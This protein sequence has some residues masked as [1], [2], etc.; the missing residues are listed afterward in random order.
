M[1][2]PPPVPPVGEVDGAQ[3]DPL[4]GQRALQAGA[5]MGNGV[6][7]AAP[8]P[9]LAMA[10]SG[11]LPIT[12]LDTGLDLPIGQPQPQLAEAEAVSKLQQP[13]LPAPGLLPQQAG[14]PRAAPKEQPTA[15]A[16]PVMLIEQPTLPLDTLQPLPPASPAPR[17][18]SE[19]PPPLPLPGYL[20]IPAPGGGTLPAPAAAASHLPGLVPSPGLPAALAPP[21]ASGVLPPPRPGLQRV[22]SQTP[23]VRPGLQPANPALVSSAAHPSGTV[24]AA[25]GAS[26]QAPLVVR[27]PQSAPQLG[28]PSQQLQQ[29]PAPPAAAHRRSP[30]PTGVA[31]PLPTGGAIP[32]GYGFT[33]GQ[34]TCLRQQIMTFRKLKAR[35]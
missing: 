32:P 8:A 17:L 14:Q 2:A 27:P 23:A 31:A 15:S 4:S 22:N 7:S 3:L 20:P 28:P 34:L 26:T 10:D 13:A 33:A 21:A 12:P 19:Q 9:S 11:L 1:G 35:I 24:R 5:P 6:V 25:S 18:T 29:Q 16:Q 30:T